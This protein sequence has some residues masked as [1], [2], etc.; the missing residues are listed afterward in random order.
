MAKKEFTSSN[1]SSPKKISWKNQSKK[2]AKTAKFILKSLLILIWI[3]LIF[4]LSMGVISWFKWV[5]DKIKHSAI[6]SISKIVWDPMIKDQY[7]SVN[8]LILWYGWATHQWWFL[9]DSIMVAS[10]N[11]D[12]NNVTLFS[13]PRDLYVKSPV[14]NGYW[15]INAIFQQYYNRTQSVEESALGFASK[16]GEMLGLDIPYYA[17]V[18]FQTFK[19]IVDSL[20]WVDVY[21]D[22]TIND[23]SYPADDMINYSPFYIEAGE[24]HLDGATALKYARSRHTTSD[25]DRALRQQKLI[26]AIKDKMLESWLSVST[27]NELY[28]QYKKYVQT[29]ISAQEM[30]WTVQFLPKIEWFS[31]FGYTSSC[32]YT[33]VSRMVP[34]CFLY[35]PARDAFWGMA[36]LLPDWATSSNVSNYEEMKT[37]VTFILT[38][39]KFLSEWASIEVV[40]SID[41]SVLSSHWLS[42]AS[43]ANSLWAKMARY[44]LTVSNV[45]NGESPVENSYISINMVWDFS[46]T[47]DAIQTFLPIQD[48]RVD[49]WS[50]QAEYDE[51]WNVIEYWTNR[52]YISV[53][54]GNDYVLG[55][56]AF[57]WLSQKRFSYKLDIEPLP[58]LKKEEKADTESQGSTE[59]SVE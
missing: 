26:I 12:E 58:S 28:D 14:T 44:G 5:F 35:N 4:F 22:K 23:P 18:D 48:I 55:N 3:F 36:V 32:G 15:R 6:F 10:R 16:V 31:S 50:V 8:V 59:N 42:N 53:V 52:A 1:L 37:F 11:P 33:N 20:W 39:R 30:L 2:S 40:N 24:Q 27:A 41:K 54:L 19:E 45:T 7:N 47:I 13:L 25:F 29:N 56:E 21:V 46:G 34:G 17:T 49:T 57:S 9:T 38:H 43:L 51:D